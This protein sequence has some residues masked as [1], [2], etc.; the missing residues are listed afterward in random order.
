MLI[1]EA[2]RNEYSNQNLAFG[3]HFTV[4]QIEGKKKRIKNKN[5]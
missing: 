1:R 4:R 5:K 3:K 2:V